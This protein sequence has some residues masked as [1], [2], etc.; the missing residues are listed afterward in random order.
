MSR[1]CEDASHIAVVG[2]GPLKE[3]DRSEI[4]EKTC[5][6]RCNDAKNKLPSERTDVAVIRSHIISEGRVD[7]KEAQ[8]VYD[9]YDGDVLIVPFM[10]E[11]EFL[12]EDS[13]NHLF[14]DPVPIFNTSTALKFTGKTMS[15]PKCK[16]ATRSDSAGS[17]PS[18][19]GALLNYLESDNGVKTIDVYGMNWNGG[20]HHVDFKNPRLVR[21]CCTK[22]DIHET[23]SPKY[24]P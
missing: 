1:W 6:I 19:G 4:A 12:H 14:A 10:E 23:S 16:L 7:K 24:L 15:F 3:N 13:H 20:N 9:T 21:E 5:V 2:N 8:K 17:G 11:N 18:T 22:C